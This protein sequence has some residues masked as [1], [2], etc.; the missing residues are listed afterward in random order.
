MIMKELLVEIYDIRSKNASQSLG[1]LL[2][3]LEKP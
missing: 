2:L 3:L 1:D